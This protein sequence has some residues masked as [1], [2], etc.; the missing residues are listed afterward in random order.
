MRKWTQKTCMFAEITASPMLP[1]N[2]VSESA[3]GSQLSLSVH[4]DS[5]ESQLGQQNAPYLLVFSTC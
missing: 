2:P 3:R 1:V 5:K 4:L